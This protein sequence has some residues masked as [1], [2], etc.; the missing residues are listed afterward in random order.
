MNGNENFLDNF[1]N[2]LEFFEIALKGMCVIAFI[3]LV[4]ISIFILL[5]KYLTKRRNVKHQEN[6]NHYKYINSKSKRNFKQKKMRLSNVDDWLT[7]TQSKNKN[8]SDEDM[9]HSI[10]YQANTLEREVFNQLNDLVVVVDNSIYRKYELMDIDKTIETQKLMWKYGDDVKTF[11]THIDGQDY[12]VN[13][14]PFSSNEDTSYKRLENLNIEQENELI[15]KATNNKPN[16]FIKHVFQDSIED[17]PLYTEKGIV[18]DNVLSK[19]LNLNQKSDIASIVGKIYHYEKMNELISRYEN[20]NERKLYK[21]G[22][23]STLKKYNELEK[24]N[25]TI[26]NEIDNYRKNISSIIEEVKE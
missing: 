25:K 17:I 12:T 26:N 1:I 13:S 18:F 6:E 23:N 4:I 22:L 9:K 11:T 2:V 15:N 10:Q 16:L 3:C 5:K 8:I 24:M 20:Q 7:N 14:V 19:R 21:D